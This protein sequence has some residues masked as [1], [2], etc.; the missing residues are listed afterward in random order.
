MVGS[1]TCRS[2]ERNA[3]SDWG[4]DRCSVTSSRC[5]AYI[6][7][8]YAHPAESLRCLTLQPFL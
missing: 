5:L 7:V 8:N 6:L 3:C 4:T 1:Y 2:V